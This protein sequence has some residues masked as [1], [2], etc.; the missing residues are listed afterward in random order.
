MVNSSRAKVCWVVRGSGNC[1][2]CAIRGGWA[3]RR[4]KSGWCGE[5][6]GGKCGAWTS[7]KAE[8]EIWEYHRIYLYRTRE[9][10][11]WQTL[12]VLRRSKAAWRWCL[13]LSPWWC[14]KGNDAGHRPGSHRYRCPV[15][16]ALRTLLSLI[17][18]GDVP[19]Y[20]F[21]E[22]LCLECGQTDFGQSRLQ[23]G[24]IC[25]LHRCPTVKVEAFFALRCHGVW[26]LMTSSNH[27]IW[28][29]YGPR[30]RVHSKV[31]K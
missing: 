21:S 31:A 30:Q 11:Q 10:S 18:D 5:M 9:S 2:T 25:T 1:L 22:R 6:I 14:M 7:D 24:L 23:G 13:H 12:S 15:A 19:V 27:L 20:G 8:R 28:L 26:F 29:L 3:K 17:I 16:K 4:Q